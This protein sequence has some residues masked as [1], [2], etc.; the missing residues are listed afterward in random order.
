MLHLSTHKKTNISYEISLQDFKR[1]PSMKK[2]DNIMIAGQTFKVGDFT[3]SQQI[4]L[5][6][7]FEDNNPMQ[8]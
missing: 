3:L 5:P 6:K 7:D 2:S 8:L 4:Q 1:I